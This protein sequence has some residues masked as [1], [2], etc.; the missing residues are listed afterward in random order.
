MV[1]EQKKA[2]DLSF[3]FSFKCTF[4]PIHMYICIISLLLFLSFEKYDKKTICKRSID[5]EK[6]FNF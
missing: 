1:R 4:I 3:Y 6:M 5:T 2:L